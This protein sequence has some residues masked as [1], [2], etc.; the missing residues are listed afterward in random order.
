M[1]SAVKNFCMYSELGPNYGL[2]KSE[3][4][5]AYFYNK[6]KSFIYNDFTFKQ[7]QIVLTIVL[8]YIVGRH[9]E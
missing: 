6:L 2:L 4:E 8:P 9:I 5:K 1:H 3:R 7:R